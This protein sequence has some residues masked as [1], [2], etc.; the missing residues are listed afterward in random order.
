MYEFDD[1]GG[2]LPLQEVGVSASGRIASGKLGLHYIAEVGNGR[3]HLSGRNPAQNGQDT[4]NG[5]SVNVGAF[6]QPSWLSG[7]QVGLSMYHDY[8]TFDN[9]NHS[10]LISTVHLV[11]VNS[12]YELLNE[13]MLV[14]HQGNSTGAPGVFHTPAFYTQLSRRFRSYRPYFRYEYIN[15]VRMSLSTAIPKTVLW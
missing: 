2:P 9:I 5:K 1:Q 6:A 15:A 13:E 14:R 11:Y 12:N 3:S 7:L 10:E 8:L 4:N